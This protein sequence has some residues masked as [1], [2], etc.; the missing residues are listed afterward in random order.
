MEF[1]LRILAAV[2]LAGMS[3]GNAA[4]AAPLVVNGGFEAT[5]L[6]A[7]YEMT[8]SNVT[9]WSTTGYNFLY[10]PG[11]ATTTGAHAPQFDQQIKLWG[12]NASG[13]SNGL[14]ASSPDGGNF[15]AADGAYG[16]APITQ[17]I[18][19]LSPGARY[20]VSFYWAGAQ[21]TGYTGATTEQW[22]VSLGNATQST[23]VVSNPSRGFSG[24]LSQSF[25]YTATSASEVLS[26]LAV[27]TPSG[28]PPF[29][30]LDGVSVT[31]VPE[32]AS[33]IMLLM[34]LVAVG[35]ITLG[36]RQA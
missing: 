26:F 35:S 17:T 7:S 27:G 1:K 23:A 33:W 9:G 29:S 8:M 30:L 14:P 32:P 21:Q 10:F 11:T 4:R 18:N 36:R 3:F 31:A 28:Q 16:T 19:G 6:S 12:T 5:S 2:T 13:V 15:I 20:K 34:G 22:K 24:W 25:T